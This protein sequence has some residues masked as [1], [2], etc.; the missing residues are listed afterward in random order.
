MYVL[1]LCVAFCLS[2]YIH[3]NINILY[4]ICYTTEK[5]YEKK[6]YVCCIPET[7]GRGGRSS[8]AMKPAT[9][10]LYRLSL[11]WLAA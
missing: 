3:S 8:A 4:V 10:K 11:Y 5:L 6:L 7:G 1:C 9:I 2:F